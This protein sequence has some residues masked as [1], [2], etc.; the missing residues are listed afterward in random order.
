MTSNEKRYAVYKLEP[1]ILSFSEI[2]Q[3]ALYHNRVIES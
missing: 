3:Y 2:M 1:F